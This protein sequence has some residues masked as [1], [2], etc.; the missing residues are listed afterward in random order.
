MGWGVTLQPATV[1]TALLPLQGPRV[2]QMG[3]R[4]YSKVNI[5]YCNP[6]AY[7][8]TTKIALF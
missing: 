7:A 6:F 5:K 8:S 2:P 4:P 3:I 1:Q